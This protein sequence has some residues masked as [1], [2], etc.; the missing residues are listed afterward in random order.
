MDKLAYSKQLSTCTSTLHGQRVTFVLRL[1]Q[2]QI[3]A[4]WALNKSCLTSLA[5]SEFKVYKRQPF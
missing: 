3:S 2:C 5:R 4:F 1:F